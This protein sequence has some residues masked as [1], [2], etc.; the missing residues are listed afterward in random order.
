MENRGKIIFNLKN[1]GNSMKCEL[2]KNL[3][4]QL[5]HVLNKLSS[6]QLIMDLLSKEPNQVQSELPCD[7]T[8]NKQWTQVSYNLQKAPNHQKSLKT[9][10]NTPPQ[11]IPEI[12][13]RFEILTNL[14][15]DLVNHKRESKSV[16]EASEYGSLQH[17]NFELKKNSRLKF[18]KY[19]G[20]INPLNT[21]LNPICHFLA[22]L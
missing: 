8:M 4:L 19:T 17:R 12:A 1:A 6:V 21:E 2:C 3:E 14:S 10:G 20:W 11:L 13:N 16:K 9:T 18:I 22:L 5:A 15:T 7:T